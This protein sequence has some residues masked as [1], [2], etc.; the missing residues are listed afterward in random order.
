LNGPLKYTIKAWQRVLFQVYSKKTL[1]QFLRVNLLLKNHPS[2]KKSK[3]SWIFFNLIGR[4]VVPTPKIRYACIMVM[5]N[6]PSLAQTFITQEMSDRP[7]LSN[8]RSMLEMLKIG[9]SHRLRG[10]IN[11]RLCFSVAEIQDFY[12]AP[13]LQKSVSEIF[14]IS[15]WHY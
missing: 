3:V 2:C 13:L 9:F 15:T 11:L 10:V 12:N 5:L 8:V 4:I 14:S 6:S 7:W 1:R